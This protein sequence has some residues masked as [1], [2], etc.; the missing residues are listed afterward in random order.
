MQQRQSYQIDGGA[1]GEQFQSKSRIKKL[2]TYPLNPK[3]SLGELGTSPSF[4]PVKERPL[5]VTLRTSPCTDLI[6]RGCT[7]SASLSL[8]KTV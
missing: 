6:H 7:S 3:I 2:T 5:H 1:H 4:I 8:L